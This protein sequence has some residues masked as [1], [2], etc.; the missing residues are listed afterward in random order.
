MSDW[1]THGTEDYSHAD[2]RPHHLVHGLGDRRVVPDTDLALAQRQFLHG[3]GHA[4][5]VDHRAELPIT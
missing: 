4:E 2:T 5:H 1:L 3:E